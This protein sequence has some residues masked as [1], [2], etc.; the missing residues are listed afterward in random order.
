M[1]ETERKRLVAIVEEEFD[2]AEIALK[3]EMVR[4]LEA[5]EA[6]FEMQKKDAKPSRSRSN[7]T[8]K[9]RTHINISGPAKEYL[10]TVEGDFTPD[11][12]ELA[13]TS[14]GIEVKRSSLQALFK[15]WEDAGIIES[16]KRSPLHFNKSS[17]KKTAPVSK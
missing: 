10:K 1:N 16:V 2:A 15:R 9:K 3:A 14:K 6:V 5:I 8:P 11:G 7:G 4:K 12:M 13:L 17:Y